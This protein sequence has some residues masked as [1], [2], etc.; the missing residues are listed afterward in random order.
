VSVPSGE[1]GTADLFLTLLVFALTA[2][3]ANPGLARM[4]LGLFVALAVYAA[5]FSPEADMVRS[6][7]LLIR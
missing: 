5:L 3:Q 7:L 6:A 4:V 1:R 2:Q